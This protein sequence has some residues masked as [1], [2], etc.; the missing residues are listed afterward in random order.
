MTI[1]AVRKHYDAQ[2][3]IPFEIH[4]ADGR[5][6][7]VAHREF[8]ALGPTGRT[9]AVAQ[10][11]DDSFDILDVRLVTGLHVKSGGVMNGGN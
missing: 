8:L 1:E 2:P 7:P 3:F 4:L 11:G 10:P 6:F 9:V 5:V